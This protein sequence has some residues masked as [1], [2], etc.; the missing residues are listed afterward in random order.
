[1][2]PTI[3]DSPSQQN[4]Y[5]TLAQGW[6]IFG[7]IVLFQL[8]GGFLFSSLSQ[9]NMPLSMFLSYTVGFLVAIFI[10]W[11]LSE[12]KHFDWGGLPIH[13]L[14]WVILITPAFGVLIEPLVTSL[15]YVEQF[16]ELMAQM[17]GDM[18]WLTFLTVAVAAPFLEEIVFRGIILNGFLKNYT[19]SKA[20][21]WSAVLFG[22]IHLNPYQFIPAFLIGLL[23][24]WIYWRTGSLWL[25]ILI[26]FVNNSMGFVQNWLFD[27]PADELESTRALFEN[28]NSYFL[29]LGGSLGVI[30]LC[31]YMLHRLMRQ[32]QT[33]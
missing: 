30:L 26:H 20:I 14:P 8:V 1:M 4:K 21:I 2:E 22:L 23:M 16:S 11:K 19:P 27:V 13:L 12:K 15:P 6:G 29:L 32:P 33:F 10:V 31:L 5:P 18:N 3:L 28:D 24:G 17:L 9:S 7:L 25:C